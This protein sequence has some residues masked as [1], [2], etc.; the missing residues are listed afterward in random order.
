MT[1]AAE[2]PARCIAHIVA[3]TG[4]DEDAAL[5]FRVMAFDL[6]RNIR[7]GS[8]SDNF[9]PIVAAGLAAK[10]GRMTKAGMALA[11][12]VTAWERATRSRVLS[13]NEYAAWEA[14]VAKTT[15]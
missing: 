9:P 4:L 7:R 11:E 15:W 12:R 14:W 6:G 5:L 13:E 2:I 1:T 10:S 3:A 8:D